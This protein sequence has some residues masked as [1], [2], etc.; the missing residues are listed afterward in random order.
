MASLIYRSSKL[1]LALGPDQLNASTGNHAAL[2]ASLFPLI[3]NIATPLFF[4]KR[5]TSMENFPQEIVDRI[6]QYVARLEGRLQWTHNG[7]AAHMTKYAPRPHFT[8][9]ATV[10]RTWKKAV[11]EVNFADLT[12]SCD[13]FDKF[14]AIVTGRRRTYVKALSLRVPIPDCPAE[15]REQDESDEEQQ[16]NNERYTNA[17]YKILSV[18]RAWE[19]EGVQNS[20]RLVIP[21]ENNATAE[22]RL[23][24]R[25]SSGTCRFEDSVMRLGKTCVLPTL[26]NVTS[27]SIY[28]CGGRRLEPTAATTIAVAFPNL[29][30]ISWN[31]ADGHELITDERIFNRTKLAKGLEHVHLRPRATAS[32]EYRRNVLND[33]RDRGENLVPS[34]MSY[35][36]LSTALRV[37][38]QNLT[39][40]HLTA[41]VDSTIFW[42]SPHETNAVTPQWPHLKELYVNFSMLTP[43]GDWYFTGPNYD[44][45]NDVFDDEEFYWSYYRVD[46]DPVTF[47]PFI[48]AFAKAVKNMPV[49][50]HF[51]LTS[52]IED[53][54]NEGKFSIAYYAPGWI[55]KRQY[56][57]GDED[58][59]VRK[60][61]YELVDTAE[62]KP[63][64]EVRETLKNVGR[65]KFGEDVL[66]LF[67]SSGTQ[68]DGTQSDGTQSDPDEDE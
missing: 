46:P 20:L 42:P 26:S 37:F 52:E 67:L 54:E 40:M 50:E 60:V 21:V 51:E 16:V 4:F 9:Y 1:M 43:S 62:W 15:V 8:S 55:A 44:P 64:Y 36:P 65:E 33:Q 56:G 45:D 22:D 25:K 18:L 32:I 35:D 2:L 23:R 27:L 19:D 39:S 66:E 5:E 30:D 3:F 57:D 11:E 58:S 12:V 31:L 6:I 17:L 49:L 34:R 29:M 38:S 24:G 13:E 61:C 47:T 48:D 63:S 7:W 14:Q 10:S 68:S 28:G 41:C 53:G 59:T